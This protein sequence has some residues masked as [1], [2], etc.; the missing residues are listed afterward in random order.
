MTQKWDG[1]KIQKIENMGLNNQFFKWEEKS[2]INFFLNR[3]LKLHLSQ[4]Y[5]NA[6]LK[7]NYLKGYDDFFEENDAYSVLL[8]RN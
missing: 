5:S 3:G 2:L 7:N 8:V 1:W 4:T 6:C